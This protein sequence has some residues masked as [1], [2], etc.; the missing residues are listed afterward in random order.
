MII[1]DANLIIYAFNT[2]AKYHLQARDWWEERLSSSE[3]I[4][5]PWMVSLAFIRV[6]TNRKIFDEPMSVEEAIQWVRS[7]LALPQVQILHPGRLHAEILFGHLTDLGTGGDNTPDA[8]L[9]A[10]AQE[11]QALLY[12]ADAG[13]ARFSGL[14]W[15]NPLK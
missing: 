11:H 2:K 7:W 15:K 1:P 14:R 13:F 10:I 9:A 6:M 4:G 12:S 3:A 8:H 5:L